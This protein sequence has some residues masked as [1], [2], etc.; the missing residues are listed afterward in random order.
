[1]LNRSIHDGKEGTEM[2]IEHPE[3][4]VTL[5]AHAYYEEQM[6][7]EE[8]AS[9]AEL[10]EVDVRQIS[11][12]IGS[13]DYSYQR[14]GRLAGQRTPLTAASQPFPTLR[15]A[16]AIAY[17]H[18]QIELDVLLRWAEEAGLTRSEAADAVRMAAELA[19]GPSRHLPYGMGEA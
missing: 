16:F 14:F 9:W 12:E 4:L 6:N 13:E 2:S 15:D 8:M 5:L 7:Y 19:Y 11:S 3:P 18:G 1:L 17:A 10:L